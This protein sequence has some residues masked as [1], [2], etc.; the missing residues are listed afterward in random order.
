MAQTKFLE[1][2]VE[3]P[4][5][6]SL[7]GNAYPRVRALTARDQ[8]FYEF[9]Q[10][11]DSE[12]YGSILVPETLAGPPAP[13]IILVVGANSTSGTARINVGAKYVARN[14]ESYNFASFDMDT[15]K[16]VAIPGTARQTIELIYTGG[17]VTNLLAAKRC[18][19]RILRNGADTIN[20]NLAAPI[21]L[22][23]AYLRLDLP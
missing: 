19:L 18:Y 6:Q 13:A 20:D 22:Q 16:S 1:F 2:A 5:S 8:L 7:A 23:N 10:G 3:A 4:R 21:E 14:G 11:V 9:L 15:I 17:S 12:W